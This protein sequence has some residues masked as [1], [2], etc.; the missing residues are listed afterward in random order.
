[1]SA[2]PR[3]ATSVVDDLE[4]GGFVHRRPDPSDRGQAGVAQLLDRLDE[5]EQ[6]ELARLLTRLVGPEPG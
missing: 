6:A 1:M 5:R 2:V 3:K 4:A